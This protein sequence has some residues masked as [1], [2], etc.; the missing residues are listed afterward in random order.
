MSTCI[1]CNDANRRQGENLIAIACDDGSTAYLC[2][3]DSMSGYRVDKSTKVALNNSKTGLCE[4]IVTLQQSLYHRKDQ[5]NENNQQVQNM[6]TQLGDA[7]IAITIDNSTFE[8]L[9]Q[10]P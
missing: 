9:N 10:Q 2:I 4:R 5:I 1:V 7:G 6:K 3:H 8:A